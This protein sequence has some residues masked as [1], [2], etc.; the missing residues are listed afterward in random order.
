MGG[1]PL[2][3]SKQSRNSQREILSPDYES[4]KNDYKIVLQNLAVTL[5]YV[6]QASIRLSNSRDIKLKFE[7]YLKN[8][9][10]TDLT[11]RIA[12]QFSMFVYSVLAYKKT[13]NTSF[14]LPRD[15]DLQDIKEFL[16][17]HYKQSRDL[18]F[19][20]ALRTIAKYFKVDL[21]QDFNTKN[22]QTISQN[23]LANYEKVDL[24]K[25]FSLKSNMYSND[26]YS[27]QQ[28]SIE[29]SRL[30]ESKFDYHKN[31]MKPISTMPYDKYN[32][33]SDYPQPV[34]YNKNQQETRRSSKAG[35]NYNK[36]QM[37]SPYNQVVSP[38][39]SQMTGFYEQRSVKQN[40]HVGPHWSRRH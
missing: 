39:R 32:K 8:P 18:S 7:T 15:F 13:Y 30:Q 14:E 5:C 16:T 33:W 12:A 36:N 38:N 37:I 2:Q 20:E 1:V 29:K 6:E 10:L 4:Q 23:S 34:S 17:L 35:G 11:S 26:G 25:D 31:T 21:P 3:S 27:M 19:Q 9:N 28:K 22:Y 24:G 40:S